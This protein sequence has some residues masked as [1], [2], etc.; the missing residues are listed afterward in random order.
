MTGLSNGKV[1]I[2]D[3]LVKN[4]GKLVLSISTQEKINNYQIEIINYNNMILNQVQND[5]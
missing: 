2:E 1:I 4:T 5:S 3:R